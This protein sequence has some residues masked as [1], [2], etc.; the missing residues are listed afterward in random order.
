MYGSGGTALLRL[1]NLTSPALPIG[2]FHFSQGLEDAVEHGLVHD[3]ASSGEWIAGLAEHAIGTLDLPLLLRL[4]AAWTDR[5]PARARR[6]SARLI[7][8]RETAELRAEDRHLGTALARVLV[9][10]GINEAKAWIGQPEA[11]HAALFALAAV[12]WDIGATDAA[13]GY[14]WSW[15]ENQVLAAIK[16]VPLGQNAGQR[17]IGRLI[18]RIPDIVDSAAAIDD[19]DIGI[20]SPMQGIASARHETQYSRLFRS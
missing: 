15:C 13:T 9:E 11:S 2:G 5:S 14:L 8:A 20:A 1:L 10:H 7:A 12:R 4:H 6:L 3:A 18:Q 19:D 16:L 17:L